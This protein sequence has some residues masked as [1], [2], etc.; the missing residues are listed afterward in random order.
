MNSRLLSET[1]EPGTAKLNTSFSRR[2]AIVS[3]GGGMGAIALQDI[4][5]AAPDSK[6]GVH[7]RPRVKRVIQLFMNGGAFQGEGDGCRWI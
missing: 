1:K 2:D 5:K 6:S 7:H 4:L 3:F